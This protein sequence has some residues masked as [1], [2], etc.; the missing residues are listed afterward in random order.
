MGK[1]EEVTPWTALASLALFKLFN[2]WQAQGI[3]LPAELLA[4]THR[5]PD[6]ETAA[7]EVAKVKIL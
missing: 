7:M 2:D 3:H 4:R 6:A 5:E 1:R